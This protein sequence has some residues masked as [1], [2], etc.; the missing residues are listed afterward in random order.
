MRDSLRRANGFT[1]IELLV[2]ILI[3]GIL[4]AVSAPSFLGQ[5][6]KAHDSATKQN[7]SVAYR[8]AKASAVDRDGNFVQGAFTATDLAAAIHA[9]EPHLTVDVTASGQS[10]PSV[11]IGQADNHI[12]IDDAATTG[13]SLA[14]CADP[15]NR[16]WT[17]RVS[18]GGGP[19]FDAVYTGPSGGGSG[20]GGTGSG[21]STIDPG[22]GG[23]ATPGGDDPIS[24]T[25]LVDCNSWVI[26]TPPVTDPGSDSNVITFVVHT[27][28]P[29][30][31]L[32]K[33]GGSIIPMC[34]DPNAT[35]ADPDPCIK[36]ITDNG[37]GTITV[38][39]ISNGDISDVYTVTKLANGGPGA[40]LD[41]STL[42]NTAAGSGSPPLSLR[43]CVTQSAFTA[44]SSANDATPNQQTLATCEW[45]SLVYDTGTPMVLVDYG[46]Q[47]GNAQ[48]SQTYATPDAMFLD[49]Q[50]NPSTSSWTGV[51]NLPS[52]NQYLGWT[53]GR[54]G[55]VVWVYATNPGLGW[56]GTFTDNGHDPPSAVM[57][58]TSNHDPNW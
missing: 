15:N 25:C 3:I 56:V 22:P 14:I 13:N 27:T 45:A 18:N 20:G 16:V 1:L 31:F 36:S 6:Q 19:T 52:W 26:D 58:S 51:E 9:S 4:I 11:A 33:K 49:T 23:T 7:L 8:D 29:T 41:L 55:H 12:Y 5:T 40:M 10:C 53:R 34:T 54:L 24:P 21:T 35:Y 39:V 47:T 48:A 43:D 42:P 44:D 28:D 2:V 46:W 30:A 38:I 57:S 37:D 50:A 32:I 17:L